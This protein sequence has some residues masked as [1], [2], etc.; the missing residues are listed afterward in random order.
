[1]AG[2]ANELGAPFAQVQGC[3]HGKRSWM[4]K[5]GD[6][7]HTEVLEGW[8]N[9]AEARWQFTALQA[10]VGYVSAEYECWAEAD[11]AEFEL[12]LAGQCWRFPLLYTGGGQGLRTRLRQV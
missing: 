8:E 3:R 12:S 10:L 5:F 2:L 11:G 6:W 7:H 1:H 9:G 4:E